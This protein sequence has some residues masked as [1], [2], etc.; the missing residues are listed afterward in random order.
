MRK[1][2]TLLVAAVAL[3]GCGDPRE[4]GP[5]ADACAGV[6]KT[7]LGLPNTIAILSAKEEGGGTVR[8]RYESSDAM[9]L[10]VE[11]EASCTFS[12][13]APRLTL[14]GATVGDSPLTDNDVAAMNAALPRRSTPSRPVR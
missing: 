8:V 12:G 11:G 9:N 6:V 4:Y 10:P 13:A 5:V 7:Y 1:L 3:G 2:A 14:T